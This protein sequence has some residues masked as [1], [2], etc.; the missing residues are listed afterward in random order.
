MCPPY[1]QYKNINNKYKNPE[2]IKYK[3]GVLYIYGT[4]ECYLRQ[5]EGGYSVVVLRNYWS[6]L[7]IYYSVVILLN[8]RILILTYY[9]VVTL[10]NFGFLIFII[11][12]VVI[13]LNYRLSIFISYSVVAL[14]NG[15][16]LM[17]IDTKVYLIYRLNFFYIQNALESA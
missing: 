17:I 13:L 3:Q 7:L 6:L 11:Y 9:S 15:G 4:L 5:R 14:L 12:S 8:F 2:H 1:Q 16:L 10:L